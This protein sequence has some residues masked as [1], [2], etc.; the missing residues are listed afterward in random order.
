LMACVWSLGRWSRC[1]AAHPVSSLLAAPPTFLAVC[2]TAFSQ[3]L[4]LGLLHG[5]GS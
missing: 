3:C 1:L 5:R 2:G 4:E